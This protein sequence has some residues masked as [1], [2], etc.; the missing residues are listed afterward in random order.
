MKIA[1]RNEEITVEQSDEIANADALAV[2]KDWDTNKLVCVAAEISKTVRDDDV[3][4]A[5]KR[6]SLLLKASRN[7]LASHPQRFGF[8][9]PEPP[10]NSLGVVMGTSI[11]DHAN[12]KAEREGVLFIHCHEKD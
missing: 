1:T 11:T 6:A 9:F 10:S 12:R 7:V 2:G 5:A 8:I 3:E 4:R